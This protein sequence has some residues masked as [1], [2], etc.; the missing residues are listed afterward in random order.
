MVA[1][2]SADCWRAGDDGALV[3]GESG[4]LV[5]LRTDLALELTLRPAAKEAL[6]F[7]ESAF[8]RIVDAEEFD[9]LG[10]TESQHLGWSERS[11]QRLLGFP[12]HRHGN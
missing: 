7:I 1:G 10:P 3:A 9:Q 5:E 8:P 11:R 4:A 12:H 2:A 6:V